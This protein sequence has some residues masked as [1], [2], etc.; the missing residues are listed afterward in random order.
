[1]GK[2]EGQGSEPDDRETVR[3]FLSV[4]REVEAKVSLAERSGVRLQSMAKLEFGRLGQ[5]KSWPEVVLASCAQPQLRLRG[6]LVQVGPI[7]FVLYRSSRFWAIRRDMWSVV[8][9][10]KGGGLTR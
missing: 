5:T 3:E 8:E 6:R 7:E 1:M 9:A 10:A 4:F 2:Q